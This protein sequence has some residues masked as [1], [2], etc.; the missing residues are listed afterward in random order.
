MSPILLPN[1]EGGVGL[2]PVVSSLRRIC[3]E[4]SGA[5]VNANQVQFKVR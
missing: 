5:I 4:T 3:A 1:A 2:L